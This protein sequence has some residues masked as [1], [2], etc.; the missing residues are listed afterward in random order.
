MAL[1]YDLH[2]MRIDIQAA[3]D[4]HF[5]NAAPDDEVPARRV[6]PADVAGA[7]PAV[8]GE[9]GRGRRRV[10]PV[11]AE[12]LGASELDLP[13]LP[14][15]QLPALRPDPCHYPRE[16]HPYGAAMRLV[17]GVRD[18]EAALCGAIADNRQ[19]P[20]HGWEPSCK[21][22]AERR[23]TADGQPQ[24]PQYWPAVRFAV[25]VP[26]RVQ[27]RL[28]HGWH[29]QQHARVSR[30]DRLDDVGGSEL[31][32][33]MARAPGDEGGVHAPQAMLVV[34]RESVDKH[35]VRAPPPG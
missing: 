4:D 18:V 13:I 9:G 7:E 1:Q 19:A 8:P 16:R 17:A 5:L 6:Y 33:D 24:A 10:V 30:L 34:Q 32:A 21:G 29:T 22:R 25:A 3:G 12:D 15:G 28:V 2:L 27:Q 20:C 23:R 26:G 14:G 11:A 31:R 35:I